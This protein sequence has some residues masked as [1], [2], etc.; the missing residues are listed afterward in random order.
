[1]NQLEKPLVINLFAGP[2]TG[3]STAAAQI[4][5]ELKWQGYSCELVAEF[6]KEKVWEESFKV[7]DDQ[8]YVFAKQ[9][10]KMHRLVGKVDIIITDSPLLFSIVYD[11]TKNENFRNLILDVHHEFENLNVFLRRKKKYVEAG[12]MQDEEGAKELDEQIFG[13]LLALEMDVDERGVKELSTMVDATK[14]DIH[15][16]LI[17]LIIGTYEQLI[18]K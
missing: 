14:A 1:M 7:L 2:G 15:E 8:V 12:R 5:S 13:M 6:A 4:F 18:K 16:N 17:P 9:A 10:H 11:S 3:K